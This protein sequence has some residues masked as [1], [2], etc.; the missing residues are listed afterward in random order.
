VSLYRGTSPETRRS[1][2]VVSMSGSGVLGVIEQHGERLTLG[3]VQRMAGPNAAAIGVH[4]LAPEGALDEDDL[5]LHVRHQ[6]GQRGRVRL[7][8]RCRPRPASACSA[9]PEATNINAA[10][11]S[12]NLA[13]DSDYEMYGVKFGGN[14]TAVTAYVMT[15]LGTVNLIDERD[16]ETTLKLVYLNFWTT[17]ADPTRPRRRTRAARVP[18]LLAREQRLDLEPP[19]APDLGPLARRRHRVP[20]RG[21]RQRLRRERDRR[22]L[23][24][25]HR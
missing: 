7:E 5:A 8:A 13:V 19:A 6:R 25:P 2:A 9:T 1:W 14:L 17:A 18:R 12:F 22:R 23:Q 4:A 24:L 20:G 11:F 3:P 16:L 21:V 10:R 15:V